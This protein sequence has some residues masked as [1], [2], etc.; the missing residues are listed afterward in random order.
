MRF[1]AFLCRVRYGKVRAFEIN[2]ALFKGK[3]LDVRHNNL[4]N[5][6]PVADGLGDSLFLHE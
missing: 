5:Y 2:I 3:N 4:G 6:N 1:I